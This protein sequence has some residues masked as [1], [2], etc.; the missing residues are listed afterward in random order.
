MDYI[1]K[2]VFM[3]KLLIIEDN[4]TYCNNL[5]KEIESKLYYLVDTVN[6]SKELENLDIES[7]NLIIADI[8][9]DD[10]NDESYLKRLSTKNTP[11]LLM[12]ASADRNIKDDI[13]KLKNVIDF[14]LKTD[15]NRFDQIIDKIK[16]LTYIE[17]IDILVV[18]DSK[19][20]QFINLKTIKD[21]YPRTNSLVA[22]NGEEAL[23]K[24][25]NNKNIR[26]IIT[27]YEMP[28]MDGIVLTKNIRR[29]YSFDEKIV[30][31]ISG[32]T[33]RDTSSRFLKVGANDF[34]H[35]P[36]NKEELK[37]RIDNNIKIAMLLEEIKD[38]A[39][40]DALTKL[41]NRRYFYEIATKTFATKNREKFDLSVI[42]LD[43]DHFKRLNDTYGHQ[44]GDLALQNF[45]SVLM[46]NLRKNDI[47]ARYGGEEFIV[48]T[49]GSNVKKAF[50][51][52]E[53]KIRKAIEDMYFKN[54]EGITIHFT[55]SAGVSDKG[56]TLDEMIK[57]ADE[58]L[59]KAKETRNK[60]YADFLDE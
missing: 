47:L 57:N 49:I 42:M 29:K 15:S 56:N 40:R 36:F 5:K 6:S 4:K 31:A 39:Y 53:T 37:C 54:E 22:N 58:M 7:Y 45:A 44:T 59:Y 24:I 55:V 25:E 43:I 48:L 2:G 32:N 28:K 27:D 38:M 60:V 19:T 1:L 51:V 35:K 41:Y 18:D 33:E 34:L 13:L 14:I 3:K 17:K 8:F 23:K 20:S 10:D 46:K 21:L 12:T 16:I 11:I 26:L 30:I 52:A 50:L 9:L